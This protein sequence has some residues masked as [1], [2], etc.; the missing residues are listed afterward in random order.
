MR[1][2]EL[3]SKLGTFQSEQCLQVIRVGATGASGRQM[4]NA[5]SLV[6]PEQSGAVL[7][8]WTPETRHSYVTPPS[9]YTSRSHFATQTFCTAFWLCQITSGGSLMCGTCCLGN[10]RLSTRH[11]PGTETLPT[12]S[13][14]HYLLTQTSV[15]TNY[16]EMIEKDEIKYWANCHTNICSNIVL[17]L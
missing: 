8:S 2:R 14:N 17:F 7:H 9:S 3:L 4:N 13:P 12:K 5:V 16:C 15:C 11:R 6:H 10:K 1:G